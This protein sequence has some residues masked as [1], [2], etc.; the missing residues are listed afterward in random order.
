M[1]NNGDLEWTRLLA[2]CWERRSCVLPRTRG[3][4]SPRAGFEL[5]CDLGQLWR[6]R[7]HPPFVGHFA[8]GRG[9]TE[10]HPRVFP[11]RSDGTFLGHAKR[12]SGALGSNDFLLYVRGFAEH[13]PWLQERANAKL[14]LLRESGASWDHL[15]LELYIGRYD[16]TPIGIHRESCGN[17]HQTIL[18]GK[19]MLVWPQNAL[20]AQ[21]DR[22]ECARNGATRLGALGAGLLS[23]KDCTHNRAAQGETI[24]FPSQHWHVGISPELS[25]ALDL[26]LFGVGRRS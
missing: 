8:T 24:Y 15:E 14:E 3:L 11:S 12:V 19:D 10:V 1:K 26:A 2:K 9:E 25:V 18:G 22:P 4:L 17:L 23:R 6:K 20:R 21:T 5:I 13:A 7:S 16:W